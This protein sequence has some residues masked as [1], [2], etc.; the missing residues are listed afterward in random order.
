MVHRLDLR[1]LR[2]KLPFC[3]VVLV[4]SPNLIRFTCTYGGSVMRVL[5]HLHLRRQKVALVCDVFCVV[6]GLHVAT[7]L[8]TFD[9]SWGV[10]L[11]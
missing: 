9:L 10:T 11:C 3:S 8:G 5:L 4:S 6:F 1:I 7:L 2:L